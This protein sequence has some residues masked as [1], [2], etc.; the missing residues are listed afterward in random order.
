MVQMY[1]NLTEHISTVRKHTQRSITR[2]LWGLFTTFASIKATLIKITAA[3]LK[4]NHLVL[5][6][7]RC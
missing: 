3:N 5:Q 7:E 1:L 2:S 6:T 4:K